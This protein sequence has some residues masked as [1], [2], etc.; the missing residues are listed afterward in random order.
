MVVIDP[1]IRILSGSET[2]VIA[3]QR[4][5]VWRLWTDDIISRSA[6]SACSRENWHSIERNSHYLLGVTLSVWIVA[7]GLDFVIECSGGAAH[8]VVE[9]LLRI[10]VKSLDVAPSWL[11]GY[12]EIYS[13]FL[14][15][16]LSITKF[17]AVI[18]VG[19]SLNADQCRTKVSAASHTQLSSPLAEVS[20]G[21]SVHT[22][23]HIV[24]PLIASSHVLEFC[25]LSC[26]CL[27]EIS[28]NIIALFK[29]PCD[30]NLIAKISLSLYFTSR[31]V[32][33]RLNL[34]SARTAIQQ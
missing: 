28:S 31:A 5:L 33:L 14:R 26:A 7:D 18:G 22:L 29:G 12:L 4:R 32:V 17:E 27:R 30:R 21:Y 16:L 11:E 19:I 23:T 34:A 13:V 15:C 10:H 25:S 2:C 6:V 20:I 3:R 1:V 8:I 9:V 24:A